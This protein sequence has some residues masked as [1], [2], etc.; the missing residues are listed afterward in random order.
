MAD[1]NIIPFDPEAKPKQEPKAIPEN[2]PITGIDPRF[3]EDSHPDDVPIIL[4]ALEDVVQVSKALDA[5]TDTFG[6]SNVPVDLLIPIQ[7]KLSITVS[8][9]FPDLAQIRK[10]WMAT[11][12]GRMIQGG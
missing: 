8:S 3:L 2:E 1:D 5:L 4:T 7:E 12:R 11:E 6:N 9:C 10:R